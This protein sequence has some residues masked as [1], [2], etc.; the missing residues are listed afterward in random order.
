MNKKIEVIFSANTKP[1]KDA[2][3]R[4]HRRYIFLRMIIGLK[5]VIKSIGN[6]NK[7]LIKLNEKLKEGENND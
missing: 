1:A 7:V 6:F 2:L 5:K 4:I 3:R